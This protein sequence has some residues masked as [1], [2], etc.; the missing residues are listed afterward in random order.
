MDHYAWI[1]LGVLAV[2]ALAYA[3]SFFIRVDSRVVKQISSDSGAYRKARLPLDADT[4]Q[5]L[6]NDDLD[7][8]Q[9]NAKRSP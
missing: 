9:R 4:Q 8:V 1:G 3:L 5:Y 2:L 6:G 7:G